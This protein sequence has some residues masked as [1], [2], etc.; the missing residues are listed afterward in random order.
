MKPERLVP[1]RRR[2]GRGAAERLAAMMLLAAAGCASTPVYNPGRVPPDEMSR[3]VQACAMVARLPEGSVDDFNVCQ[4]SLS[5]ALAS[6]LAADRSAAARRDCLSRGMI[7]GTPALSGCELDAQAQS[8][9]AAGRQ[10]AG[11]TAALARTAPPA[12]HLTLAERE[13]RACAAVGYDPAEPGFGQCVADLGSALFAAHRP[14][15]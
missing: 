13:R 9:A 11:Q 7:R 14:I 2:L 5:R 4:E 10:P 6:R 3:I 8:G 15:M 12:P 1:G